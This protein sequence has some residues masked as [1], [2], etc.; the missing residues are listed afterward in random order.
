MWR[1]TLKGVVAHRLRYALT[2]LSVLLGV[3]FIA[4]TFVLTD[5]INSTFN[6]LYD[7]IY[8]GTAA[9]VRAAQPFN[10]GA[11]FTDQRQ[12]IDASLASTVAKVP[13]VRAV[14]LYIEGYAQLVGRDGKPIGKAANGRLPWARPGP[15]WPPSTRCGCCPAGSPRA[16]APRW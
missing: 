7:Q 16:R 3:A 2:A 9:Q 10:P 1:V 11:S 13:G 14:A 5:T 8:Q 6:N 12:L 4:G 15:T